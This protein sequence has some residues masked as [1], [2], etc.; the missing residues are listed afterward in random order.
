MATRNSR[1]VARYRKP[2]QINIGI[3]IFGVIFIFVLT[4]VFIY[5]TTERVSAY[6]VQSGT[7]AVDNN[8]K[9]LILREETVEYA[10]DAGYVNHYIRE[11]EKA[12][13]G[14]TVYTVDENGKVAEILNENSDEAALSPDNLSAIQTEIRDFKADYDEMDF[15]SVYAFKYGIDGTILEQINANVLLN[16][17][18]LLAEKGISSV[19][20]I[21]AAPVSGVVIYAVDGLEAVTADTFTAD[22]VSGNNYEKTMLQAETIV[23]PGD[24]AYKTITSENWSVII[25]LSRERAEFLAEEEYVEVEFQKDNTSAWAA[26]SIIEKDGTAYGKLDFTN[27]MVRFASDRYIDVKLLSDD[28]SG[29]K[30]P[31]TSLVE[32]EF[33]TVPE[34][35]FTKGGNDNAKGVIAETY[36]ENGKMTQKFIETTIYSTVEGMN[37]ID[38]KDF[39]PGNYL[40]KPESTERYQ[41]GPVARLMGVYN[42]NKGFAVFKQV[43]ILSENEEYC[44]VEKNTD[45]GLSIYDHIVLDSSTVRE[46]DIVN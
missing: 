7:I 46:N 13:V 35:Y 37:Y 28:A 8:Y 16:I 32:K 41:I 14:T 3:V 31:V 18:S 19:F 45:Y 29:L 6:E 2:H 34:E 27:S 4:R 11:G 43:K 24:P 36:D 23:N 22:M 39:E 38:K 26:F 25:E 1:K 5:F 44:I 42:I 21:H 30:I 33:Y 40:V 20:K 9:G 10:T 12:G 15:E 17:D